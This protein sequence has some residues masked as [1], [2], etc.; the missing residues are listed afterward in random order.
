[1]SGL[2][3]TIGIT[4]VIVIKSRSAWI[5]LT[6]GTAFFLYH[7]YSLK[8]FFTKYFDSNLKKILFVFFVLTILS[9]AAYQL[10]E[11]KSDSALGRVFIWSNTIDMI[12]DHPVTGVGYGAFHSTYQTYQATYFRENND[13]NKYFYLADDNEVAYNEFLQIWAETGIIGLALFVVFIVSLFRCNISK[14]PIILPTISSLVILLVNSLFSYTIQ[15][16]PIFILLTM[17]SAILTAFT[18]RPTLQLRNSLVT[19]SL[20]I[21]ILSLCIYSFFHLTN[22]YRDERNL[23]LASDLVKEDNYSQALTKLQ[24][25][26]SQLISSKYFILLNGRLLILNKQPKKAIEFLE[27][28]KHLFSS[29]YH[30][31][32]LGESYSIVNDHQNAILNLQQ[33]S[34]IVPHLITPRFFVVKEYEKMG[35]INK[36][37][38]LAKETLALKEKVPSEKVNVLKI[39]LK[40]LIQYHESNSFN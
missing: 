38:F 14:H 11:L 28:S 17:Y 37:L 31:M 34:F 40:Q 23:K 20:M 26:N 18:S 27:Q 8:N 2:F 30:Y 24:N 13:L 33:A 32:L 4:L 1:M 16:L 15:M 5:G 29:H 36:T 21:G 3:L 39:H 12:Y 35:D 9:F 22:R 6:A 10:F 7:Q 19:K 25:S